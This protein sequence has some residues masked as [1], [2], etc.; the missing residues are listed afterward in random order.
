MIT[1]KGHT[2]TYIL[3]QREGTK[4]KFGGIYKGHRAEDLLKVSAKKLKLNTADH[5]EVLQQLQAIDQPSLAKNIELIQQNDTTYIIQQYY[6]GTNLKTILK[7]KPI[8][9]RVKT[10]LFLEMA[11][12]ILEGLSV[13]HQ[14]GII[15][16]DIKPANII[17][18]HEA[19]ETP[20]QWSGKKAV[21][22]D[23]EKASLLPFTNQRTPFTL[24][25]SPPE[26]LLIKGHLSNP[27]SDLF[28]LA[29][30]LYECIAGKPPYQDCNAEILLNLQL[31]YPVQKP[32]RMEDSFFSILNKATHKASFPKP[33]RLMSKS[34]IETLLKDGIINRYQ[35][36][37]AMKIDLKNY[38]KLHST[39]KHMVWYKRL[40]SRRSTPYNPLP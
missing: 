36:A 38:L 20:N 7:K 37:D 6:E 28:S 1:L 24:V 5:I 2:G 22:I 31:T 11:I 14:R 40:L 27:T 15:H 32:P 10:N 9:R 39:T 13:L 18:P 29:I 33:L 16:R 3:N 26:Q 12:Q 30:T 34:E 8:Y 17:I 35:Q 25:Y 21:L 19:D 4:G 23:F